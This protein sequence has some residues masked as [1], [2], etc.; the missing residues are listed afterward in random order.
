[1]LAGSLFSVPEAAYVSPSLIHPLPLSG[2]YLK[3]VFCL[4]LMVMPIAV[5]CIPFVVK[6]KP[7]ALS[8]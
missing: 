4:L 3:V 2:D 1:L 5:G 7:V 8:V 6:L